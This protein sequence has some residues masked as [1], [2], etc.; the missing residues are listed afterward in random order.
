MLNIRMSDVE[1]DTS[2]SQA[3]IVFLINRVSA[4]ER[5]LGD[6]GD[7][8]KDIA[9]L[10]DRVSEIEGQLGGNSDIAGS[11]QGGIY[12][13]VVVPDGARLCG[14]CTGC[15]E[16]HFIWDHDHVHTHGHDHECD[17][18]EDDHEHNHDDCDHD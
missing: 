16:Y 11:A 6:D 13:D 1:N 12:D 4:I 3:D 15:G 9:L 2:F 18:C 7:V 8:T 17:D 10:L 5:Q 14:S